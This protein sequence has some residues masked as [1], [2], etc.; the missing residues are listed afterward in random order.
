MS[1]KSQFQKLC[2]NNIEEFAPAILQNDPSAALRNFDNLVAYSG[3]RL[4]EQIGKTE[5]LASFQSEITNLNIWNWFYSAEKI[6]FMLDSG[7]K[8]DAIV[9]SMLQNE[10]FTTFNSVSYLLLKKIAPY[11]GEAIIS[12]TLNKMEEESEAQFRKF[13]EE[14]DDIKK[15]ESINYDDLVLNDYKNLSSYSLIEKRDSHLEGDHILHAI[16][17][18]GDVSAENLE[19]I[20]DSLCTQLEAF[21][22]FMKRKRETTSI[23]VS[24][25]RTRRSK[26]K[27]RKVC[28]FPLHGNH[29]PRIMHE[30]QRLVLIL[31]RGLIYFS[32]KHAAWIDSHQDKILKLFSIL[33]HLFCS[34][35]LSQKWVCETRRIKILP[36]E[37]VLLLLYFLFSAISD[38]NI[39]K[40]AIDSTKET[41][42]MYDLDIV[43]LNSFQEMVEIFSSDSSDSANS[44]DPWEVFEGYKGNPIAQEFFRNSEF[45]SHPYLLQ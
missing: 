37:H 36:F 23:D 24:P 34:Q 4:S 31:L 6:Q 7:I 27:K 3:L 5:F 39:C 42:G 16:L 14:Q 10:S 15:I 30:F 28:K 12:E 33:G 19:N 26:P 41:I 1:G 35:V 38:E 9:D 43:R 17:H 18:S 20:F 22:D 21:D 11:F 29:S 44:I 32:Q 8:F 2:I 45:V 40:Q 25:R 13:G